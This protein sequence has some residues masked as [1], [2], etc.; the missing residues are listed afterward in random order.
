MD[1]PAVNMMDY[2]EKEDG[3]SDHDQPFIKERFGTEGL[4]N[5]GNIFISEV[6]L[7]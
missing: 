2:P 6:S 7:K 1:P 4:L 5:T 3:N